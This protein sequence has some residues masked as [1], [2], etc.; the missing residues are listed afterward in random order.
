MTILFNSSI[1]LLYIIIIRCLLYIIIICFSCE[2]VY[3]KSI[4]MAGSR[5][6]LPRFGYPPEQLT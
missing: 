1:I 6:Q 3:Y 5:E 2:K 4:E